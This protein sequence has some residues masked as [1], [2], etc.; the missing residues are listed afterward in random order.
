VLSD[1]F[2]IGDDLTKVDLATF[3]LVSKA[4]MYSSTLHAGEVI[5]V[6]GGSAH[7]VKNTDLIVAISMNYIDEVNFAKAARLMQDMD[8]DTTSQLQ[9]EDFPRGLFKQQKHLKWLEFKQ[10]PNSKQQP[11]FLLP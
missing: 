8:E 2:F 5:Y 3:P 7:Q 9:R 4:K 6:P 1:K 10:W 11:D